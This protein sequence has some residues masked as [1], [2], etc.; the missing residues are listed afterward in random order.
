MGMTNLIVVFFFSILRTRLKS[1]LWFQV[2]FRIN[3]TEG[4]SLSLSYHYLTGFS[5]LKKSNEMHKQFIVLLNTVCIS[6]VFFNKYT[7]MHSVEHTKGFSLVTNG[8]RMWKRN[9]PELLR[10]SRCCVYNISSQK[11][12]TLCI[13]SK[14]RFRII[15]DWLQYIV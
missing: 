13:C 15:S 2:N 3:V 11:C 1:S 10:F 6:L 5:L 7:I 8:T 9:V 4:F 12:Y 14:V